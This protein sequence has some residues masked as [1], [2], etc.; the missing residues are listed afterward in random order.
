[1][2]VAFEASDLPLGFSVGLDEVIL[3]DQ[4]KQYY[5]RE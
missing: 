3:L 2:Q 5:C 1:M 4:A